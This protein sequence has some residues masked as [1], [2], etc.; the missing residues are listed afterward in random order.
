MDKEVDASSTASDYK[1]EN[2]VRLIHRAEHGPPSPNGEGR[3]NLEK[4]EET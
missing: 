1:G 3:N 2:G 4:A